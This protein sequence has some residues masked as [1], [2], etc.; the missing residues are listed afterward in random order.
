MPG[1][2]TPGVSAHLVT[3]ASSATVLPAPVL[4][5]DRLCVAFPGSDGLVPILR[6]VEFALAPGETL[7][8]VG[9]SGSGKSLTA[10][11]I[12]GLLPAAA[13][14][15]SGRVWFQG[16]ELT[17]ASEEARRRVRGGGIGFVFQEA[18][19]ALSPVMTVGDQVAEA[20]VVQ[21][22]A[23]WV[24]ARARA[25][26][27]LD[28]VRIPD[29]A[30]RARDY[31]HQLSGGQRQR[32]MLAIALACDPP[33]LV[34]DEP[35][36]ALDVTVQADV[37]DVLGE[38]QRARPLAILLITHDLGVVAARAHRVA[39]MYAGRIVE[40]GPTRQIFD[41]PAHPYT[42]ALVDLAR[43]DTDR[44]GRRLP[45]IPGVVPSPA[46]VP[47]GCAFEPRCPD[48]QVRC[49]DAVPPRVAIA[50]THAVACVLH[51]G[52]RKA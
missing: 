1:M 17:S 20:L 28:K 6:D 4:A 48:R 36:T 14:V 22:R 13:V 46:D 26:E 51:D 33:V 16:R 39:V 31:P 50:E 27:L 37:L 32:V 41:S 8:C 35:T 40:E 2:L 19:A 21:G 52:K 23:A 3:G 43:A 10:L 5:V 47:D 49:R 44:G 9:E 18:A 12:L 38:I 25:V 24:D 15:T 42:R 45:V 29:A 11:A 34:A 7:A 30:V